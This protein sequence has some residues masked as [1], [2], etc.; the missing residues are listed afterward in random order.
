V[1]P[2]LG[3]V[4][5]HYQPWGIKPP[6][7]STGIS[8]QNYDQNPF[9]LAFKDPLMT[10]SDNWD[11]PSGNGIPLN[12]LGQVHRGTPWQTVYLKA[13]N[14]LTEI[15]PVNSSFGNVGTNTWMI[16][17]GDFD[18]NDAAAMAPVQDWQL[19]GLLAD[20]FNTNDLTALFSVNNPD[21]NAWQGLL[22]GLTALTNT[23][24]IPEFG[25]TQY[26][27]LMVSS[28]SVQATIIANAI[29][30]IR[31]SQPAQIF[32]DVGD[33]FETLELSEASPFLNTNSVILNGRVILGSQQQLY[34]IS[35][36]AYEILPNQLLP[37][38]RAD[39]VG[40]VLLTNNQTIV[41]F[42]GYDCHLYVLQTSSDLENW[43]NV[44][45]NYPVQGYFSVPILP[46]S[47]SSKQFYRSVLLP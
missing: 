31:S 9:N 6:T 16:W 42:T 46:T 44:S 20:L 38:L 32:T 39:S 43:T 23:V 12:T 41:Q 3:K 37:L 26:S 36:E 17:T 24:A 28:N 5:A 29:E 18:A 13:D 25:G 4:N 22:D 33:V 15:N 35:D 47:N 11:F 40:S 1:L 10:Q 7:V 21:P 27:P 2:D 45:T 30:S 34:G 8:Q 19:A 14:I